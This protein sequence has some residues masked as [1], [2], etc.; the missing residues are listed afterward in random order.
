ML[1]VDPMHPSNGNHLHSFAQKNSF[2]PPELPS[3]SLITAPPLELYH[4]YTHHT[5]TH[6][7]LRA[8]LLNGTGCFTSLPLKLLLLFIYPPPPRKCNHLF[9][10]NKS[11]NSIS[12]LVT[13]DFC[14]F[15]LCLSEVC[16]HFFPSASEWKP[17]YEFV[18]SPALFF[19]WCLFTL[20]FFFFNYAQY[21]II[22]S[23]VFL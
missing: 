12:Y 10:P 21:E 17:F 11:N 15:L 9:I 19:S 1:S 2:D 22:P 8:I 20:F 13:V 5:L 14:D 16:W 23:F 4:T 18:F 3:L 7:D 6:A